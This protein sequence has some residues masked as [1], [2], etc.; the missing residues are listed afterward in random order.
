MQ[1]LRD[2]CWEKGERGTVTYRNVIHF[3]SAVDLRMRCSSLRRTD[4][5]DQS[6]SESRSDAVSRVESSPRVVDGQS[7]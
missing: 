3:G 4:L 5:S 2:G 6:E 1:T 7:M